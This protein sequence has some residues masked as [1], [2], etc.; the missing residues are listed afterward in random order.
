MLRKIK[1]DI[2]KITM[3]Y[4]HKDIW[5]LGF[6]FT[7]Y[8]IHIPFHKVFE[9]EI[10]PKRG[11]V[12]NVHWLKRILLCIGYLYKLFQMVVVVINTHNSFSLRL[13]ILLFLQK[14]K[15]LVAKMFIDWANVEP[16]T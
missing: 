8:I 16:K 4:I 7:L 2:V 6:K 12:E 3:F 15:R 5:S 13:N 10:E 14:N 1:L 9:F 11:N